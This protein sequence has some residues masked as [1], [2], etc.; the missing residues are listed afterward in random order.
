MTQEQFP[1]I[2]FAAEDTTAKH[3]F[4]KQIKSADVNSM[5][6]KINNFLN[7]ARQLTT[8]EVIPKFPFDAAGAASAASDIPGKNRKKME[9]TASR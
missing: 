5:I 4:V 2:E 7:D 9:I 3:D 6:D 1:V 8:D